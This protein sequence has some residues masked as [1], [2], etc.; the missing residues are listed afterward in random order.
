[1]N[2]VNYQKILKFA[3]MKNRELVS[4]VI[5]VLNSNN[6]DSR[7]PKRLILNIATEKAIYLM[8]QKFRDRS[9]YRESNI[10]REVECVEMIKIDKAA[11][12]IV[13]F[14]TCNTVMRSKKKLPK[15]IFSRYGS[16]LKEVTNVD[17]GFE[18]QPTTISKFR[19]DKK[20]EEFGKDR[21]F[22]VENGYLYLPE[23][24]VK[25]VHLKLYT[26]NEYDILKLSECSQEKCPNP[27]DLDFICSDKL[28]E[29]VVEETIKALSVR[30][31]IPTD[32][33]PNMDSNLKS[34]TTA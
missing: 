21:F 18:F 32:E 19:R 3:F 22:Y 4:R 10:Y 23:S 7:I 13:E 2:L 15:L 6:K 12:D 11:C 5:G 25:R 16:S 20:R 30:L 14:R 24:E 33:N 31:Q 27:W 34:K 8:A 1:M 29:V 9:L 26:P 28:L 17:K